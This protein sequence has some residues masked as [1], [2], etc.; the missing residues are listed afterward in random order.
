MNRQHP[1]SEERNILYT[2]NGCPK[3]MIINNTS[4]KKE[5][6]GVIGGDVSGW[7]EGKFHGLI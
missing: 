7:T 3:H 1:N 2:G 6:A 4:S 5:K